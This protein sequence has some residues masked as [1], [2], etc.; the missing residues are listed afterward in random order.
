MADA[1][2][3]CGEDD[4]ACQ[5][6]RA[7]ARCSGAPPEP[8]EPGGVCSPCESQALS[9]SQQLPATAAASDAYAF[10]GQHLIASYYECDAHAMANLV[11]LKNALLD[12]CYAAGA[13]VLGSVDHVFPAPP[14]HTANGYT[15][16]ALLSESHAT[17]HLYPEHASCFVDLFTCGTTCQPFKFDGVMQAYLKPAR[18]SSQIL[19]RQ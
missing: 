17:V 11:A 4:D 8:S 18:V 1:H 3:F 14:G 10:V 13:T 9:H 15:L 12:G 7:T 6:S 5:R 16:A 2:T 19:Q